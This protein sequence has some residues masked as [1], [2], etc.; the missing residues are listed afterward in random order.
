[1]MAWQA[2]LLTIAWSGFVVTCWM[3]W[4]RYRDRKNGPPGWLYQAKRV[5][6]DS[7][8]IVFSTEQ[9]LTPEAAEAMR[10]NWARAQRVLPGVL[11]PLVVFDCGK[12]EI[13]V[14]EP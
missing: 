8:L 1:M 9:Q 13:V 12:A 5:D 14:G 2:I 4:F 6:L 3:L 10:E 7:A 11:P